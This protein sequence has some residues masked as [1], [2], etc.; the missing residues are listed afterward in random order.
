MGYKRGMI[1][2][3][4]LVI[5]CDLVEELEPTILTIICRISQGLDFTGSITATGQK[6]L[7]DTPTVSHRQTDTGVLSFQ[8]C[9][10]EHKRQH[11][12]ENVRMVSIFIIVMVALR[13][14]LL[15]HFVQ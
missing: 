14:V 11:P 10:E 3:C 7:K 8:T 6:Y 2:S 4:G 15:Q 13:L 12:D 9:R 1:F 5:S